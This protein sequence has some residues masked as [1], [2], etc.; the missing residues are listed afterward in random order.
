MEVVVASVGPRFKRVIRRTTRR[1]GYDLV[2]FVQGFSQLQARLLNDIDFVVDVG[3]NVG[4]YGSKLRE[5]GFHGPILSFEPQVSAFRMLSRVAGVAGDWRVRNV[6]LGMEFTER[7]ELFNSANSV[8]SSLHRV[9]DEHVRA[10][11]QARAVASEWVTVE[12]LDRELDKSGLTGRGWLKLDVQGHE[13]PVLAGAQ[14]FLSSCQVI[15]VE[16]SFSELYGDQTDWLDI[17]GFIIQRGFRLQH[18]E[19]GFED[20]STG[21]LQQADAL[22]VRVSDELKRT[23]HN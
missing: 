7:V 5:L 14:S 6:A 8:S 13:L 18:L 4:Q 11:P 20:P 1:F 10:A 9:L 16:L 22:F 19:P 2:P 3:A 21:I 15:Q 17:A 23:S 12:T